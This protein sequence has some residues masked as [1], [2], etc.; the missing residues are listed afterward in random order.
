MV[1]SLF[2]IGQFHRKE[3]LARNQPSGFRGITLSAAKREKPSF[4]APCRRTPKILIKI[5]PRI[6]RNLCIRRGNRRPVPNPVFW[7]GGHFCLDH[8][9]SFHFIS[10]LLSYYYSVTSFVIPVK[11]G[12]QDVYAV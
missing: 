12:I 11:T 3:D 8:F 7:P 5:L 6:N 4:P 10:F 1:L 9:I 2:S